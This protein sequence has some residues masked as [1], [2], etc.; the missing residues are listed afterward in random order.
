MKWR[1]V[2][3]ILTCSYSKQAREENCEYWR[4]IDA[5]AADSHDA[6]KRT[7]PNADILVGETSGVNFRACRV[8]TYQGSNNVQ[9]D[10]DF[11]IRIHSIA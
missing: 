7:R 10:E 1:Y 8:R 6:F 11:L 4:Y 9:N 3:T 2:A 5:G